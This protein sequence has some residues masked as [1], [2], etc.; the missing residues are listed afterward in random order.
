[1]TEIQAPVIKAVGDAVIDD[2]NGR[3]KRFRA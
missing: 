3:Y 2:Y 1:M